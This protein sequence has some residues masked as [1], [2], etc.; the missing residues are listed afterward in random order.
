MVVLAALGVAGE[1]HHET[2]KQTVI[3]GDEGSG[4]DRV[5]SGQHEDDVAD[6]CEQQGGDQHA[7]RELQHPPVDDP[8]FCER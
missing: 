1:P 5:R 7:S 2:G 4:G 8:I 6:H 3:D